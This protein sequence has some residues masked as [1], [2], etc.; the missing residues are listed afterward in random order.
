M[1]RLYPLLTCS[2]SNNIVICIPTNMF[3]PVTY[4]MSHAALLLSIVSLAEL[5]STSV[6]TI[7]K[8]TNIYE[9]HS[10]LSHV[11]E[12][13]CLQTIQEASAIATRPRGQVLN[14]I[15]TKC[16]RLVLQYKC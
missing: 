15:I 10:T 4:N 6:N 14:I 16:L 11:V 13:K 5:H 3:D 2:L 12:S 7:R 1:Y 9:S 8:L